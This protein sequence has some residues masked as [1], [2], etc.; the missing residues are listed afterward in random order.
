MFFW[1][2]LKNSSKNIYFLAN[3]PKMSMFCNILGLHNLP[4]IVKVKK[5]INFKLV[6]LD[7]MILFLKKT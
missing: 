4:P 1:F 3:S 6:Y 5:S 2:A 7:T